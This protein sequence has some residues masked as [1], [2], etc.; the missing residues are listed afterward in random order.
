VTKTDQRSLDGDVDDRGFLPYW[1]F[2]PGCNPGEMFEDHLSRLP[3][4]CK[5]LFSLP[6]KLG[7]KL[8]DPSVT[9]LYEDIKVG[10]H[11]INRMVSTMCKLTN[12]K[13]HFTNHDLRA[14]GLVALK[15]ADFDFEE[16]K[17]VS[18]HR[19][20]KS[21]E[22]NYHIG[23]E[24]KKKADMMFCVLNASNL[25]RGDNFDPIS[26]H[27][28]RKNLKTVNSALPPE[29]VASSSVTTEQKMNV[30]GDFDVSEAEL[31]DSFTDADWKLPEAFE[32][33][34]DE[35]DEPPKKKK[36]S[37][38]NRAKTDPRA[39][40]ATTVVSSSPPPPPSQPLLKPVTEKDVREALGSLKIMKVCLSQIR[41]SQP[42]LVPIPKDMITSEVESADLLVIKCLQ[43]GQEHS[44]YSP[45]SV[46]NGDVPVPTLKWTIAKSKNMKVVNGKFLLD[47]FQDR[48]V[49]D[50][51]SSKYLTAGVCSET[52]RV[53]KPDPNPE[54]LFSGWFFNIYK[55]QEPEFSQENLERIILNTG[56]K[57]VSHDKAKS[58]PTKV[59]I[60][61]DG[62]LGVPNKVLCPSYIV[63]CV[64][65]GKILCEKD[66]IYINPVR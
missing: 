36:S 32:S 50:L 3:P 62:H 61:G 65:E 30:E 42:G 18:G 19:S 28:R 20:T 11:T 41:L 6:K 8:H 40:S 59:V 5:F 10:K 66:Y 38:I 53:T 4:D 21:I 16:I 7:L 12:S 9:T 33:S 25:G 58:F 49:P 64:Q 29:Q 51:D 14:T 15:K 39:T 46:T 52:K 55:F 47:W 34:E 2:Y 56:G 1:V 43:P 22:E 26:K 57:L 24:T 45:L 60:L 63:Q 13:E 54:K 23:L 27:L 17:K 31:D 37:L 44:S 48:K 35:M